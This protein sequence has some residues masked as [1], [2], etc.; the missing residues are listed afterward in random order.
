MTKFSDLE[1]S[2]SIC[3]RLYAHLSLIRFRLRNRGTYGYTFVKCLLGETGVNS[4]KPIS[5]HVI[6]ISLPLY[7]IL[8]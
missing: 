3:P 7:T 1:G 8:I 2:V 5:P 6:L 4:T